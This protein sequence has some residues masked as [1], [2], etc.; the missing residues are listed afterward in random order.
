MV[1]DLHA[2]TAFSDGTQSPSELISEAAME[3]IDVLGITD[4]DTTAG[5]APAEEAARVY[6][7]GLVRGMEI[8]CRHEGISVHILSYLHDPYDTGLADVVEETRRSRLD[9]THLIIEKLAEDYPIDM[10]AVLSVSGEDAT[11]GRPHIADA[12]VAAGIVETRSDAFASILSSRG[13]YHVTLPTID[14]LTAIRLI[15]EAGG[16]S[17][18][19]HPRA[20]MRGLVVSDAAMRQFIEAGLDGLEV[21]HRDNPPAEREAMRRLA[22]DRDLI[23]T[24]SSDYHGTGKPNRLGEHS[25]SQRMLDKFLDRASTRPGGVD[26]IQG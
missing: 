11:I 17:V 26:F 18:F 5:W 24:G 21:D 12:L 8:S 22:Q 3:G 10:D 7:L 13:K 2:H 4:H 20:A 16:V 19:A 9:R 1:I 15:R 25:T 14:P 23:I 6:G